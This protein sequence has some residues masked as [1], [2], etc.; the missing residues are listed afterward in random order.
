MHGGR[1]TVCQSTRAS[2]PTNSQALLR[3]RPQSAKAAGSV[4]GV[5][6]RCRQLDVRRLSLVPPK[7]ER[8]LSFHQFSASSTVSTS[9]LNVQ[10]QE[11]VN[12]GQHCSSASHTP[13]KVKPKSAPRTEDVATV[14][15]ARAV[16]SSTE[17]ITSPGQGQG[18]GSLKCQGKLL[19]SNSG[20]VEEPVR[21]SSSNSIPGSPD[22]QGDQQT[23][24]YEYGC[25]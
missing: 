10:Q 21:G 2:V 5:D 16:C 14:A 25:V 1:D 24:W 12:A 13:S 8:P 9:S 11:R 18:D 3:E 23:V 22:P 15:P 20:A 17:G 6:S 4:Q 7:D 19:E